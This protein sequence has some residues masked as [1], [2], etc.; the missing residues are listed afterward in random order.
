MFD[1]AEK[2]IPPPP[3]LEGARVLFYASV[4]DSVN[5]LCLALCEEEGTRQGL[6]FHC[7][8]QWNIRG[9]TV[10][11]STDEAK[12]RAEWNYAELSTRWIIR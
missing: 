10:D 4:N 7:D 2:L 8:R 11:A 3:V 6:L 9:C 1:R 5:S 12:A